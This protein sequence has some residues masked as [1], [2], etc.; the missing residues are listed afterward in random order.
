M[1]LIISGVY[2]ITQLHPYEYVYYN[3]FIGGVSETFRKYETDYWVT[4]YRTA[5]EWI[6]EIADPKSNVYV[7]GPYWIVEHYA[8]KDLQT[9]PIENMDAAIEGGSYIVLP[10]RYDYD[11]RAFKD[12]QTVYKVINDG[13]IFS[14]V[15][16]M[17]VE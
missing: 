16:F 15:K 11:L 10:S 2:G 12:A 17:P 8:R 9:H 14:V 1:L 7:W 5:S 6:N 4:S 3:Q 13:A